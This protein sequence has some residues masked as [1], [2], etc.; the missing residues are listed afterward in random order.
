MFK[1]LAKFQPFESQRGMLRCG[2]AMHSN[3]NLPGRRRPAGERRSPPSAL[4]CYWHLNQSDDRLECHWE[5]T[6]LEEGIRRH[7]Y[8]WVTQKYQAKTGRDIPFVSASGLIN[9]CRWDARLVGLLRAGP[10]SVS[11]VFALPAYRSL[12]PLRSVNKPFQTRFRNMR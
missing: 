2:K 6:D 7:P 12:G 11:Q 3:D 5:T 1:R 4:A 9:S 8:P 10:N